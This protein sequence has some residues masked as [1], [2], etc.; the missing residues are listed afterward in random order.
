MEEKPIGVMRNGEEI[1]VDFD[2]Y[3]EACLPEDQWARGG[4]LTIASGWY[5]QPMY[6]NH[7][8]HFLDGARHPH[9]FDLMTIDGFDAYEYLYSR[10]VTRE[11]IDEWL[12]A[13]K[14]KMA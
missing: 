8:G 12:G 14:G 1:S 5:G 2:D 4:E 13:V 3:T 7:K 9:E 11:E 6:W 10:C